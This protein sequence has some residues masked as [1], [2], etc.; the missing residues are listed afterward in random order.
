VKKLLRVLIAGTVVSVALP[1]GTGIAFAGHGNHGCSEEMQSTTPA[2][3]VF[4]PGKE[5]GQ[6]VASVA[7]G[8]LS[9]FGIDGVNDYVAFIKGDCS[10][11]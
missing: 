11:Y 4:E 7:R 9:G 5:F 1:F 10:A 6:D 8:G 2:G 3:D